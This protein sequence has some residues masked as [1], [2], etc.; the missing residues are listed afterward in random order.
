MSYTFQDEPY[1]HELRNLVKDKVCVVAGNGPSLLKFTNKLAT[2]D[3]FGCNDYYLI[4]KIQPEAP[5]LFAYSNLGVSHFRNFEYVDHIDYAI[6]QSKFCFLNRRL[7][8]KHTDW[9]EKPWV[10]GIQGSPD[11]ITEF[12]G[13]LFP[14]AHFSLTPLN[15]VGV[16]Y[17]QTYVNLQLAYFF[18][19]KTVYLV[20]IGHDYGSANRHFYPDDA[21]YNSPDVRTLMEHA[22][23]RRGADAVYQNAREVFEKDGRTILNLTPGK[24]TKVFDRCSIDDILI[25]Q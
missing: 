9:R 15:Y 25:A 22:L 13:T 16:G 19:F 23:Y 18:G 7:L 3:W 10:Y 20:G 6:H 14:R 17:T 11:R 8:D 1:E 12:D 5:S 4:H 21:S 2:L 24:T